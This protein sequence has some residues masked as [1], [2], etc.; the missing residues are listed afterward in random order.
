MGTSA[1]S[2]VPILDDSEKAAK[3]ED[4][5]RRCLCVATAGLLSWCQACMLPSTEES[6]D[7]LQL[8]SPLDEM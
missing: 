5:K 1:D 7:V 6:L 3:Q 4:L 8:V 2:S